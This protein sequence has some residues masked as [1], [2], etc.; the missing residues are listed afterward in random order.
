MKAVCAPL[1]QICTKCVRC[2]SCGSTTPGK[3]WDAQWSHDFSLCH[4]C[5]KLF[6]KG[7]WK[8]RLCQL[9]GSCSVFRR[10]TEHRWNRKSHTPSTIDCPAPGLALPLRRESQPWEMSLS[11]PWAGCRGRLT[12]AT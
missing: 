7:T 12:V 5:A 11:F 9:Q 3:G 6:A 8:G 2:K 4:D 1:F 10:W